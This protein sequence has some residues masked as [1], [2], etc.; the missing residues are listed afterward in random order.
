MVNLW[1]NSMVYVG[2]ITIRHVFFTNRHNWGAPSCINGRF[3]AG[4]IIELNIGIF[5]SSWCGMSMM[6]L[7]FSQL[8]IH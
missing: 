8:E 6:G 4:K 1:L 7:A 2:Y 5:L 3:L